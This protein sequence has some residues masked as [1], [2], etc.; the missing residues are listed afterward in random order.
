VASSPFTPSYAVSIRTLDIYRTTHLRCPHLA[1]EPFLK[2]LCDMYGAPYRPALRQAFSTCYDVYLRLREE[3]EKLV[4]AALNRDGTWRRQNPCSA[5]TYR[6]E[7]EEALRFE[8][9]VTM[10]GNN[11]LKRILRRDTSAT[12]GNGDESGSGQGPDT[13]TSEREDGRRVCGDYYLLREVVDQYGAAA[14]EESSQP[15]EELVDDGNPYAG[16]WHNMDVQATSR[17][18]GIFDETGIFLSLCRHGFA[19]VLMDMVRSGEL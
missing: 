13:S 14:P 4:A 10:D 5:C 3:T 17:S 19:L 15:A 8:M 16:R 1:I 11:S 9:L 7:G 2:S 18:W 12:Q 6:L